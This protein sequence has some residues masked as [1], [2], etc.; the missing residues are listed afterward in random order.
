MALGP[1][2]P[3]FTLRLH[4][5]VD[6]ELIDRIERAVADP[7]S[8]CVSRTAG[9][10]VDIT[11]I[12]DDRHRWSPCIQ[13][14]FRQ[15]GA[16][17]IVNGLV[18]PHPNLW[19]LFAFTSI[20]VIVA[21]SFGAMLGLAQ[22]TLGQSAWGLWAIPV[23]LLLLGGLYAAS[24]IGRRFADEQSRRLMALVEQTLETAVP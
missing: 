21:A 14:E 24:Q 12:H 11:V 7:A 18:G 2:R 20:T 3:R 8:R 9:T 16:D 1:V 19:T 23:G 10:H 4:D 6:A 15:D 13:L 22:L 5:S 17:T